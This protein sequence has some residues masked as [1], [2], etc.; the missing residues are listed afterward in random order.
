[1][2]AINGEAAHIPSQAQRDRRQKENRHRA[3]WIVTAPWSPRGA[4]S[5]TGTA[6]ARGSKAVMHARARAVTSEIKAF[7]LEKVVVLL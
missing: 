5:S 6:L 1:M 3:H 7:I 2:A 4:T